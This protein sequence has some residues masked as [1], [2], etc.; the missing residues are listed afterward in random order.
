MN[1]STTQ[2]TGVKPVD[3]DLVELAIP[4]HGVP[5]QDPNPAAQ[6]ALD[7][8]EAE[9]EPKSALIGG[10]LVAGSAAGAAV[11]AVVAGPVGVLVGGTLGAVAGAIGGAE[12]GKLVNPEST[13]R[14]DDAPKEAEST[15]RG[16]PP[17]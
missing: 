9:R 3:P 7:P 5:S 2:S 10:G 11:G 17:R 1:S 16:I 6:F 4:G 13:T 8:E 15:K 14:A 12:A